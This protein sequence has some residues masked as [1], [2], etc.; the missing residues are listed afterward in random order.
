MFVTSLFYVSPRF[1]VGIFFACNYNQFK[2]V[3]LNLFQHPLQNMLT[4]VQGIPKQV[5][6]DV[7]SRAVIPEPSSW[8]YFS[9]P[10]NT[11]SPSSRGFRNQ[12]GMTWC[13]EPSYQSRHAEFISVSP[14]I[15]AHHRPGD[16]ET[17][18][19]GRDVKADIPEPSC[20]IY[21]SIPCTTYPP[22]SG[23]FRNQFGMTWWI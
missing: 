12:F 23:S 5:R 10:C 9:T 3:M 20:W 17:S 13:Q 7:M 18:S 4:I 16:S 2:A 8:I 19:E 21:F 11:C 1:M 6:K 22:M 14:A 15:H